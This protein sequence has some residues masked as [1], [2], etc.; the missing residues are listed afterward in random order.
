MAARLLG[1]VSVT[2]TGLIASP[3]S[4]FRSSVM[5]GSGRMHLPVQVLQ[6]LVAVKDTMHQT[7]IKLQ[8][9]EFLVPVIG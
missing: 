9:E 3:T 5:S 4:C 1:V 8:N 2:G 6:C 7:I